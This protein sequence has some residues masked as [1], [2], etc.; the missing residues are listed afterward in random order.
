MKF[1]IQTLLIFFSCSIV[2]GQTGREFWFAAPDISKYTGDVPASL[3]ITALYETDVTISMPANPSFTPIVYHLLKGE[4]EKILMSDI[5]PLNFWENEAANSIMT[6]SFLI[7]SEPGEISAYYELDHTP[8][9]RDIFT[10]K[11]ECALGQEFIVSSQNWLHNFRNDT[12]TYV[13]P[14]NGFVILATEDNTDITIITNGNQLA[15]YYLVDTINITLDRGETFAFKTSDDVD[16]NINHINGVD[17]L[18]DKDIAITIYDDA[19]Q[20]VQGSY[21]LFADQ[22]IPTDYLGTEYFIQKNTGAD[23]LEVVFITATQDATNLFIDGVFAGSINKG[24]VFQYFFPTS[25]EVINLTSNNK[26]F[27]NQM[28]GIDNMIAGANLPSFEDCIGSY[29][30]I[31]TRTGNASD[32]FRMRLFGHNITAGPLKN[33]TAESFFIVVGNDIVGYDTTLVPEGFFEYSNDSAFVYIVENGA[34]QGS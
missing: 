1:F 5:L 29:E 6:R 17:V 25:T 20:K 15:Y 14:F 16:T 13:P 18:S 4:N 22:I 26:I 8:K 11:G 19:I 28:I 9:N 31:F 33:K 34:T 7:E 3:S 24:E 2:L 21:E 10:L 23:S 30:S 12:I 27:V 32:Q